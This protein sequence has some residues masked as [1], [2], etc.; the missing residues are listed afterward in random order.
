MS[1]SKNFLTFTTEKR[2]YNNFKLVFRSLKKKLLVDSNVVYL[3]NLCSLRSIIIII[4]DHS[5]MNSLVKE[6]EHH[7]PSQHRS[8]PPGLRAPL[9]QKRENPNTYRPPPADRS[10]VQESPKHV[11]PF[12][13]RD[14][15]KRTRKRLR[16]GPKSAKTLHRF[17][18]MQKK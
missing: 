15:T 6:A 11:P 5:K 14:E 7:Q 18:K 8:R 3:N 1:L 12:R 9:K 16:L 10:H 2:G 13:S 17:P 4:T